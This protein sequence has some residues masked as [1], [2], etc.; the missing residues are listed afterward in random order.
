MALAKLKMALV[1]RA[2]AGTARPGKHGDGGGLWLVVKDG[3]NASWVFRYALDGRRHEMGLGSVAAVG[4]AEARR[5]AGGHRF[6]LA[7]GNDP[8]GERRDARRAAA[9]ERARHVSFRQA[10]EAH[11]ASRGTAGNRK[12]NGQWTTSLARYAFPVL[13]NMAVADVDR[14]AVLRVLE[15]IWTNRHETARRVRQRIEAILDS[16]H[17]R[18]QREEANPARWLSLKPVLGVRRRPA[19]VHYP[20]MPWRDVPAFL[21]DLKQQGGLGARALELTILTS[22]RSGE[23]LGARWEEFDGE[24]WTVPPERMKGKVGSRRAHRVP[25]SKPAL[26]IL[27]QLRRHTRS[28]CVFPGRKDGKPLTKMAMALTL[29]RMNRDDITTHGFRSSFRSWAADTGQSREAAEAALAHRVGGV[30]GAYMRSDLI[31]ARRELM[32]AWAAYSD[33]R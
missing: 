32:A 22:L 11:I 15:P 24:T 31:D 17:A 13:A 3:G 33:G 9:L 4:L 20:A 1:N 12:H 29:R 19:V 16:A 10:A 25:L 2:I 26:E 27:K 28:P 8:M 7:E 30:E 21:K 23:V 6:T 5:I 18:G 14:A